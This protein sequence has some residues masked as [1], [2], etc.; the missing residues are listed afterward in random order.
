MRNLLSILLTLILTFLLI[1]V[2]ASKPL[3]S[4]EPSPS[5]PRGAALFVVD[6]LMPEALNELLREGKLKAIPFLIDRGFYWDDVISVFPSMSV[7]IDSSLLTGAYPDEHRVPALVW[8]DPDSRRVINYG[9]SPRSVWK[10]GPSTTL[11]WVLEDLNQKHL[12]P[13][14]ST[15]HET[16]KRAGLRSGSINLLVHRGF[17]THRAP[18]LERTLKGPDLL[19]LGPILSEPGV[20]T[21]FSANAFRDPDTWQIARRWLHRNPPP[22]FLIAYLSDLDK[23]VHKEGPGHRRHLLEID[24]RLSD[25]LSSFGSWERALDRYI[26]IL[27]GDSGHVPVKEDE[28]HQIRLEEILE[29]F[30]LL[31]PGS[32][33]QPDEYDFVVAPNEQLA[34]LY[35][36]RSSVR[37]RP[38]IRRLLSHPGVDLVVHRDGEM[39][40]VRSRKGILRFRKGGPW[41]DPY[42]TSWT[43]SGNPGVLDLQVDPAKKRVGFR[44]YPDAFRQLLGAAGAQRSPCLLVTA[45]TG[46]EFRYGTSPGHPG[47]G[48]HGS[49]K[50]RE[51]LVPLIAGGTAVRPAHRRIVDL[52]AWILTLLEEKKKPGKRPGP[53]A[54]N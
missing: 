8:Y 15:I 3:Q 49:L 7:V 37:I 16:L 20:G 9:D 54:K 6:S 28:G 42:G 1:P 10:Q 45:R 24:R 2:R 40:T 36:I 21:F 26:F 51:M 39:I 41:T 29:G 19:A 38:V 27:M 18:L 47:G 48:S 33:L 13:R 43:F 12:S 11:Q 30:R 5:P 53:G 14:V 35:P 52:K 22:D 32:R 34:I 50:R 17:V 23:K 31:P 46:Y 44:A 25:L 4:P